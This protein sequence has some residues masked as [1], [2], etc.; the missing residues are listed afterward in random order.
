M[1]T[2][3]ENAFRRKIESNWNVAPVLESDCTR[4]MVLRVH[5]E[6]DGTVK[7]VVL[8]EPEPL[9]ASCKQAA[10]VAERAIWLSS[11]LP[12]PQGLTD[13]TLSFDHTKLQ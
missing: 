2:P 3:D 11:P 10:V 6:T 13:L 1:T 12:V 5:L 9:D 8:V 4:V 7:E